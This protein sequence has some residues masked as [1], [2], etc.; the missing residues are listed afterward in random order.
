VS[1]L[2][3]VQPIRIL[4]T[5][6]KRL[7]AAGSMSADTME[8]VGS[9]LTEVDPNGLLPDSWAEDPDWYERAA[10][11]LRRAFEPL[12]SWPEVAPVVEVAEGGASGA[13]PLTVAQNAELFALGVLDDLNDLA[14]FGRDQA[15]KGGERIGWIAPAAVGVGIVALLMKL[16][17]P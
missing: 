4:W 2:E 6:A 7:N 16:K 9:V 5:L 10:V 11:A 3:D 1:N 15:R 14:L 8:R 13:R 17:R 12:P